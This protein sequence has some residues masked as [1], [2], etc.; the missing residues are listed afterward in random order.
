MTLGKTSIFLLTFFTVFDLDRL[1]AYPITSYDYHFNLESLGRFKYRFIKLYM[2]IGSD[3]VHYV[4]KW[5]M[6]GR[7]MPAGARGR[8]RL[9]GRRQLGSSSGSFR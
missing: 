3:S 7:E 2:L 6:K 8:A 9:S 4:I 1:M 5:I